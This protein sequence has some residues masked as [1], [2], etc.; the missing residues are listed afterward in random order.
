[1]KFSAKV[2][3]DGAILHLPVWKE[4]QSAGEMACH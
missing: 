2:G 1:M 4:I 3:H